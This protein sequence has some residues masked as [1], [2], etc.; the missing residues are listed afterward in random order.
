[1]VDANFRMKRK[2]GRDEDDPELGSGWVY[3]VEEEPYATYL[4]TCK[5]Q[6]EV[7]YFFHTRF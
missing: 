2:A 3:L 7:S 4:G 5:K 6:T 1:M